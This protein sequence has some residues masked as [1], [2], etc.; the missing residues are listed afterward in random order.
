MSDNKSSNNL[1]RL[2]LEAFKE[3][4]PK[5]VQ[6]CPYPVGKYEVVN[7]K[8]SKKL[9]MMIPPGNFRMDIKIFHE[10]AKDYLQIAILLEAYN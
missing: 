8:V 4:C 7:A 10:N 3:A 2:F 6:K 1:V 9:S 5:L